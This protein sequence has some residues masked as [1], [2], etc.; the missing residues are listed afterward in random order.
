M[1]TQLS[2]NARPTTLENKL[3]GCQKADNPRVKQIQM[4]LLKV[5]ALKNYL[6]ERL[7]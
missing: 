6:Y 7:R 1:A 2:H 5:S 4:Y 3:L